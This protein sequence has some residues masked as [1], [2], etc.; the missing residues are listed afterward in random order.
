MDANTVIVGSLIVLGL[1]AAMGLAGVAVLIAMAVS[2][3]R[4]RRRHRKAT[5]L[6]KP[7]REIRLQVLQGN[8]QESWRSRY[9]P[10]DEV[11]GFASDEDCTSGRTYSSGGGYSSCTGS[12]SSGSCGGSTSCD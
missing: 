11:R 12:V 2:S 6:K 5:V 3:L 9:D 1:L 10:A 4:S 7:A 8:R